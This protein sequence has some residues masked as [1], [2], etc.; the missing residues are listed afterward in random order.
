M[1][2]RMLFMI[3]FAIVGYGNLGKGVEAALLKRADA[4]IVGIFS[5]RNPSTLET[6]GSQAFYYDTLFE[7][8][9]KIDVCIL[10]G[11][12]AHDLPIQTPEISKYFNTVDSYDNHGQIA[13]HKNNVDSHID[14]KVSIISVGW[15]P[16][17]F[18]LMRLYA[19][20]ILGTQE[21][22]WGEGVSQGHSDALRRIDGVIDAIQVTV[23][24]PLAIQKA[25]AGQTELQDKHQ[26]VCYVVT[27]RLDKDRLT[28]EIKNMPNYFFGYDT[29]VHYL[30][31][32]ELTQKFPTMP[33]GGFV[34]GSDDDSL[35]EFSL[36][37]RSN[38][39]FTAQVLVSYAYA[40]YHMNQEGIKGAHT[41]YD[42]APKYL[43][44]DN[45]DIL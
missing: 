13:N 17:L 40:A 10:C 35:M 14:D 36:K 19:T 24:N 7:M 31:Q 8:K 28:E 39:T 38:P 32:D 22:F 26:R 30:T 44:Q 45:F 34:I 12:S 43:L 16:G 42:V 3:R 2:W 25:R 41:V 29:E 1:V 37:L 11:G 4:E 21:T 6:K 23:P 9:D 20:S 27:E 18:S 5:R 15:D 33:H